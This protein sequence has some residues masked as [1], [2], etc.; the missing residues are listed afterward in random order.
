MCG[1]AGLITSKENGL[2]SREENFLHNML[3]MGALRGIHGTG[4][5]WVDGKTPEVSD[6]LKM[7][8][9][10]YNLLSTKEW[11]TYWKNAKAHAK[12][13][14][15]HHRYATKGKHT[16]D[17][18]HP[19]VSGPI[20][21]VHNGT[22][23][24]GLS[25]Y[26]RSTEVDSHALTIGLE[27]EG[28]QIFSE[29]NGAFACVWH[30]ERDGTLNITKNSQR[31]LSMAKVGND[32]FFASEGPMLVHALYR[33][34]P[35]DTID[36]FDLKDLHH[37]KWNLKNLGEPEV[38]PLPEKKPIQSYQGGSY[39]V[40]KSKDTYYGSSTGIL[41]ECVFSI[42]E[43][44]KLDDKEEW[45]Y[46]G[47]TRQHEP[48]FFWSNEDLDFEV[49]DEFFGELHNKF[50]NRFNTSWTKEN[51]IWYSIRKDSVVLVKDKNVVIDGTPYNRQ[52]MRRIGKKGCIDCNEPIPDA[53]LEL[54]DI[55][56][57]TKQSMRLLC[58]K[59][60]MA[61]YSGNGEALQ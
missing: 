9:N 46:L 3:I 43:K 47:V 29:I 12:A 20:T 31:P 55:M 13:F 17:N 16:T 50:T 33:A 54:C 30:D 38:A 2:F 41:E 22:V 5:F 58:A 21:M 8:G 37:Y 7:A 11:E 61:Y 34:A 36:S 49:K 51:T 52:H 42:L 1:I 53:D 15:M 23:H 14:V 35:K 10:P 57:P 32:W 44:R 27:K 60:S 48:V 28:I 39:G 19:F 56:R 45:Y 4:T 25:K 6:Y 26:E 59:C 40:S 18:A 24:W